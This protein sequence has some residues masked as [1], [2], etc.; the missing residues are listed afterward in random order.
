MKIQITINNEDITSPYQLLAELIAEINNLSDNEKSS[1]SI[2]WKNK[3]GSK[4][5]LRRDDFIRDE[6]KQKNTF[7]F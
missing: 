2:G 1:G 6:V 3:N 4:L 5:T 7:Q